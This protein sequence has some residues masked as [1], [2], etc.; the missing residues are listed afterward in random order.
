MHTQDYKPIVRDDFNGMYKRGSPD[1]CPVDHAICCENIIFPAAK[2][3]RTRDGIGSSLV[4]TWPI[5]KQ[6]LASF[7]DATLVFLSL[8]FSG[9]LYQGNNPTPLLSIPDM[10]DFAG[11]NLFN[12][13][14]ILPITLTSAGLGLANLQVWRGPGHAMRDAAGKRPTGT[15]AAAD[16]AADPTGGLDPGV[17]KFTVVYE[18]DTGFLTPPDL[19]VTA[20]TAPGAK[21]VDLSNVPTGPAYVVKRHILVTRGD[22]ELFFFA[23]NGVIND[24]TT[25]TITL[26][27]F[28]SDLVISAD[29]LF[30]LLETIVGAT[31][32]GSLFKY[33]GRLLTNAE[34]NL[35]RVS[36]PG[37]AESMNNVDGF[38]QL[39]SEEDGNKC[40][41]YASLRDT[42]YLIKV[43]GIF[44][45][46]DNG[47]VPSS[48]HLTQVD[49]GVGSFQSGI[50]TI[51]GSQ[52]SLSSNETFTI[53]SRG[54]LYLFTG[55][56]S[57]R[58]LTWKVDNVWKRYTHN[59][60]QNIQVA[61]DPFKQLIYILLPTNGSTAP[62][63]LLVGD[64]SDGLDYKSIKWCLYTFPFLPSSIS[65]MAFM[66]D[67]GASDWDYYLRL[68]TSEANGLYKMTPNFLNDLSSPIN[69]Y[70]QNGF[71]WASIGAMNSVRALRLR[72]RSANTLVNSNINLLLYPQDLQ[73]AYT[74]VPINVTYFPGMDY[75]RQV[76]FVNEKISVYI[77]TNALNERLI[78][79][80]FEL[81]TT[82]RQLARPA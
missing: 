14:Y 66:D 11:L 65:L 7:N 70:W 43:I 77:G 73:T 40:A 17:H 54:G 64:Y 19:T 44:S 1:E 37:D 62:N 58:P 39:P 28:D 13:C 31:V 21:K 20:Y 82:V 26:D 61:L 48:W 74:A 80:R 16:G 29:Y 22:E 81:F 27:F 2:E 6:F 68:G 46:E 4:T 10:V 24:N 12:K 23:P 69:S 75:L 36:R 33:H 52:P 60:Q 30:D 45:T 35:V 34:G 32:Y 57:V 63:E 41:S 49:G 67:D 71:V 59:S 50:S 5:K 18:T 8:D 47:D 53:A 15:I 9:N 38:I 56:V 76:N 25:T 78:V 55:T 72:V 79:N 42:L 3:F 51:T